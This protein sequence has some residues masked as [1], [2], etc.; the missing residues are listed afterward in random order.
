MFTKIK[1]KKKLKGTQGFLAYLKSH[2]L[3]TILGTSSPNAAFSF[4]PVVECLHQSR[5]VCL[6]E[7]LRFVI[8]WHLGMLLRR[9]GMLLRRQGMLLRRQGML[10]RS[11]K[12]ISHYYLEH[13]AQGSI[14]LWIKCI[15]ESKQKIKDKLHCMVF[16]KSQN[17]CTHIVQIV[18]N[19][20]NFTNF[21]EKKNIN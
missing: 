11:E 5:S 12:K 20:S 19:E 8:A 16:F 14:L 1:K 17:Q 6:L 15:Q 13:V 9:Q 4:H 10:L 7:V 21:K 18:R 2:N 3:D